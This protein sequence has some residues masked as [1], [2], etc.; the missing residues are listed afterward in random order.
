M[1]IRWFGQSW[2]SQKVF[3]T[4]KNM[5]SSL[6]WSWFSKYFF[7]YYLHTFNHHQTRKI[8]ISLL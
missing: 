8:P 3:K 2:M 6:I 1:S 4:L 7:V 5:Y